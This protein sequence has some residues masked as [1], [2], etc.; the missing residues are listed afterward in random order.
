MSTSALHRIQELKEQIAKLEGDAL[1]ELRQRRDALAKEIASVDAELAKL[2][3]E[4]AP[5]K[6]GPRKAKAQT[7]SQTTTLPELQQLLEAA[8]D[9]T[10]SIR[11]TNLDLASVKALVLDHPEL[12]RLGGKGPWPT[13][14]LVK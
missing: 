2:S 3:G 11:K 1:R 6:K 12:L 10:V 8:P 5:A 7:P 4:A 14:T 13:V 9:K